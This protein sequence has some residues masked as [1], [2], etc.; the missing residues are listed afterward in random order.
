VRWNGKISSCCGATVG[1]AGRFYLEVFMDTEKDEK[2]NRFLTDR[3]TANYLFY[4]SVNQDSIADFSIT[5]ENWSLNNRGKNRCEAKPLRIQ[6]NCG[7]GNILDGLAFVETVKRLRRLGHKV[8]IVAYG[9]AGSSAAWIMQEADVRLMGPDSWLLIHEASSACD[10]TLSAMKQEVRR[11]EQ[12][13]D[14]SIAL[15]CKRSKLTR[16]HILRQIKNGGQW[17][18]D[19]GKA[20]EDGLIDGIEEEPEVQ[21]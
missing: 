6:L 16:E 14:Q 8:T 13:Q 21:K 1:G 10:G 2:C 18:I 20:L 3:D 9:R 7:G 12:L 4:R 11:T 19:A 17:W 5:L 15:L